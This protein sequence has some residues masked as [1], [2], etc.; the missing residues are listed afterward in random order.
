MRAT[1]HPALSGISWSPDGKRFAYGGRD[2]VWVHSVGDVAGTRIA[3][4]EVITAVAWSSAADVLAY[5]D[6]G[7]L[8]MIGPEGRGRRAIPIAGVV[9]RPVWAPAGDRLAIVV[10]AAGQ[11]VPSLWWTSPRGT[12]VRQIQWDPRNRWIG[13][14]GWF[15]EALYLFVGLARPDGDATIEWWKVRIAYPDFRR[16]QSPATAALDPVLSPSG[17]WVAFAAL[18]DGRERVYAVRPDGSG[19]HALSAPVRHVAGL[20]WSRL[21]DKLA[22]AVV[23]EEGRA[24]IHGAA[25]SSGARQV[26]A[27]FQPPREDRAGIALAWSPDESH[28]AYS[29]AAGGAGAVWLV[30]FERR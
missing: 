4:G 29:T 1:D 27:P 3:D 24:E 23:T 6:R 15:P 18:E 17:R 19:S 12:I 20:A 11:N 13:A 10:Q 30:R 16:L 5:V 9:S 22:Y 8:W 26:L 25:I 14:L 21:D 28:L 7:A 2:G